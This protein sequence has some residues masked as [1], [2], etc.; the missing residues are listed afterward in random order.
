MEL[1]I[2]L[3]VLGPDAVVPVAIL[4]S[5]GRLE[6]RRNHLVPCKVDDY[7]S[8]RSVGNEAGSSRKQAPNGEEGQRVLFVRCR[9]ACEGKSSRAIPLLRGQVP[10]HHSPIFH[11]L[12]RNLEIPWRDEPDMSCNLRIVASVAS[13]GCVD[14]TVVDG[15]DLRPSAE[16]DGYVISAARARHTAGAAA[17]RWPVEVWA[18]LVPARNGKSL[19]APETGSAGET[20]SSG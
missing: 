6:Y 3:A 2:T 16:I 13:L 5:P 20:L 17:S 14:F 11:K 7:T 9:S 19:R 12:V 10:P 15:D 1:S 18:G 4:G 8:P